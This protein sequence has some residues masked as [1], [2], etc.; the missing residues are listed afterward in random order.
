MELVAG[1]RLL[2][3]RRLL[4]L[5]AGLLAL[6]VGLSTAYRLGLP[7]QSRQYKVGIAS[8]TALVDTPSSQVV[9][10][11]GGIG[12]DVQTLSGR[13]SLLASLMTSSPIKDEIAAKAKVAPDTLVAVPPAPGGAPGST[14]S[15]A[16]P[17]GSIKPSDRRASVLKAAIPALETSEVPII[18]VST[19]APDAAAAARLANDSIAVL[20]AYLRSVAGTDRVPAARRVVVRQLGPARSATVTRG[21]RK[22]LAVG[23][24]AGLFAFG[25]ALIIG[26]SGLVSGWRRMAELERAPAPDGAPDGRDPAGAP[27]PPLEPDALQDTHG[28]PGAPAWVPPHAIREEAARPTTAGRT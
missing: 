17:I 9:D 11:G 12:S 18:S 21:P 20:Q 27:S 22:L 23:V 8:V 15:S 14:T 28:A 2:W 26:V 19:Q 16:D 10:L 1:M 4:V 13:A 3:R 24:A 5:A 25:C 7:P 6:L